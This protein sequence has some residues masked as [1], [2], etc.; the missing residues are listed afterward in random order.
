MAPHP[1][2][3]CDRTNRQ[4]IPASSAVVSP[5]IHTFNEVNIR[6][7]GN[8]HLRVASLNS[9]HARPYFSSITFQSTIWPCRGISYASIGQVFRLEL[10]STRQPPLH[11]DRAHAY[12]PL[13]HAEGGVIQSRYGLL[14][15]G[16]RSAT[17]ELYDYWLERRSLSGAFRLLMSTGRSTALRGPYFPL[18]WRTR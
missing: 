7:V 2:R 1:S 10:A 3:Y 4:H 11:I 5:G 9:P 18:H 8:S 15:H 17:V 12:Y 16:Y 6:P 13:A 14:A